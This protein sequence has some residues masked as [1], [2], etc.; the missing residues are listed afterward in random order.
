MKKMF[1]PSE[2]ELIRLNALLTSEAV[3]GSDNSQITTDPPDAGGD[4]WEPAHDEI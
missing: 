4:M 1:N 3:H 2:L